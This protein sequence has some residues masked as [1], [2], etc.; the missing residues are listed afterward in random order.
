MANLDELVREL[1]SRPSLFSTPKE[2]RARF[3]LEKSREQNKNPLPE[4]NFVAKMPLQPVSKQPVSKQVLKSITN[5]APNPAPIQEPIQEPIPAPKPI[6][7]V[8]TPSM[9]QKQQEQMLR[10]QIQWQQIQQQ[11]MQWQQM[12][13]QQQQQMQQMQMHQSQMIQRPQF[14]YVNGMMRINYM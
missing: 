8:N 14:E 2:I 6:I 12:Q 9:I 7:M 5:L 3:E 1:Y 10:E 4:S 11:Q 13:W